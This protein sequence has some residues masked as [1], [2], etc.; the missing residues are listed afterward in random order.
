MENFVSKASGATL[1]YIVG[2]LPGAYIGYK[3]A[4]MNYRKR[5]ATRYMSKKPYKKSRFTFKNKKQDNVTTTQKDYAT[6]Y[7]KKNMPRR[8]KV[9]WKKF[10]AKVK[11]VNLKMK[12]LKTVLF[13]EA[14]TSVTT[15]PQNFIGIHLY[16][17][18]GTAAPAANTIGAGDLARIFANDPTVIQSTGPLNPKIGKLIFGSAVLDIT[19]RNVGD[20]DSEV[21]V[22]FCYHRKDVV[23]A[24]VDA[25]FG[26]GSGSLQQPIAT[27]NTT[28][29][30]YQRGV[31]PFDCSTSLSES[32]LN[33]MK[34]QKFFLRQGQ[35]TFIQH[36]DASNHVVEWNKIKQT[37]YA[38]RK[39]TYTVLIVHK[40]V[41]GS[42]FASNMAIGVTRK[43]SYIEDVNGIDASANGP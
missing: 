33:I 41:T 8:K 27:G 3:M 36:R 4:P 6:Q 42:A 39:L 9:Q 20:V 38:I 24:N 13:N 1:G 16:G 23:S 26:T 35:T 5:K 18:R 10:S 7:R 31:T 32:G 19:L 28:L 37:G 11:A 12:G 22:Y 29:D 30:L 34:K 43:Y 2:N 14:T 21:D 15:F 25:N 17:S 40:P